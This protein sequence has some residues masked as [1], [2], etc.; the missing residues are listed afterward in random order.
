[1][2]NLQQR[3]NSYQ[4]ATSLNRIGPQTTSDIPQN[5]QFYD[6]KIC[7]LGMKPK[8]F[9]I[10]Y[11][12]WYWLRDKE[13]LEQLRLY[14]DKGTNN[15]ADYFTKHHPPIHHRQMRPQ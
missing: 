12:K 10:W 14:W 9:K 11:V 4:H 5:G 1:M 3:E 8:R 2:R 15:D 7:K 13:V 6:R